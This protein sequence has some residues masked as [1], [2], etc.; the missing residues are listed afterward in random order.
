VFA[1][2]E[3]IRLASSPESFSGTSF[4]TPFA[5]GLAALVLS[6]RR[7][8]GLSRLSRREMIATLRNQDHLNLNCNDH[9]FAV[10]GPS[11]FAGSVAQKPV[12]RESSIQ[13]PIA[14][15][16]L[17]LLVCAGVWVLRMN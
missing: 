6:E 14:F 5:A 1:P 3:N 17:L 2:G 4:S 7:L 10:D 16:T 12:K 9:T 13:V 11:C 15:V 8:Q